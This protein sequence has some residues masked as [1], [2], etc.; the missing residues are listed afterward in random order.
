MC[1]MKTP[2]V[3]QKLVY[4]APAWTLLTFTPRLIFYAISQRCTGHAHLS[5]EYTACSGVTS[6]SP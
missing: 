2:S 3:A 1:L 6:V 4:T 5:G